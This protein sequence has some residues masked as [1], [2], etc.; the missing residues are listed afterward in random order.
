MCSLIIDYSLTPAL[1]GP[2]SANQLLCAQKKTLEVCKQILSAKD[3]PYI[4]K[5]LKLSCKFKAITLLAA[6]LECRYDD[7]IEKM[8]IVKVELYILDAF[9]VE[10]REEFSRLSALQDK[11]HHI[12]TSNSFP[13]LKM[14]G[15]YRDLDQEMAELENASIADQAMGPAIE[16]DEEEDED[17]DLADYKSVA[18]A[19]T[20]YSPI[21]HVETE[22]ADI[23]FAIMNLSRVN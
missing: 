23:K 22:I 15:H 16:E 4:P 11:K 21:E 14:I 19:V 20:H 5:Q 18:T 7:A 1:S 9:G 13:L 6:L 12:E 3:L 17:D 8:M 10:L 2:C